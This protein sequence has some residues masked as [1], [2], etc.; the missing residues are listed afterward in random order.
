MLSCVKALKDAIT[1]LAKHHPKP[2]AEGE[3]K[4]SLSQ[5]KQTVQGFMAS[6]PST[7][8]DQIDNVRH[9][10]SKHRDMLLETLTLDQRKMLGVLFQRPS[11]L[12]QP[13][14]YFDAEPTFKQSYAPQSGQI[15]G[16]LQQLKEDFENSLTQAQKEELANQA[17]YAELKAAKEAEIAAGQESID[18]KKQ[19]LAETDEKLAQTKEDLEDTNN[20]LNADQKFLMDLK[21]RCALLD[22]EWEQ[23][24]KDRKDE[25]EAVAKAMEILTSDEARELFSKTFNKE[26]SFVQLS[27]AAADR[28]NVRDRA[29]RVLFSMGTKQN[30]QEMLELAA[31][32]K[33]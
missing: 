11:L 26:P 12:A 27:S 23:R 6:L 22:K 8:Q 13:D 32:L 28:S 19:E 4:A 33:L 17:A 15:F 25:L 14:D 31:V 24:R 9:Q 18:S 10:M 16:I 30:N 7:F 1:V 20:S 29:A 3:A 2:A 5:E 21:V